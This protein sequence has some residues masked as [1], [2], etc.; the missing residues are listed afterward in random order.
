MGGGE[1]TQKTSSAWPSDKGIPDVAS[2]HQVQP[3]LCDEDRPKESWGLN[4]E[5][6]TKIKKITRHT[7]RVAKVGGDTKRNRR[8]RKLWRNAGET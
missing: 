6:V 3:N 7:S 8:S 2:K 5:D 4:G 1:R